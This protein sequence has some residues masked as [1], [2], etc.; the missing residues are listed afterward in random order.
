[1]F[2]NSILEFKQVGDVFK[3]YYKDPASIFDYM[4]SLIENNS[5]GAEK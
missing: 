5:N 3:A 2:K 1:M 4:N